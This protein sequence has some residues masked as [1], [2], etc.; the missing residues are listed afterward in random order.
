MKLF[1]LLFSIL[2]LNS[3]QAQSFENISVLDADSLIKANIENEDFV[4]MD[5]RTPSEYN[6]DHLENAYMRNFYDDD[7]QIQMDSLNKDFTY[8]IYCQSGNRSGQAF[9]IM[10]SLG[11]KTV[12]NMLGGISMWKNNNLPVT[13]E[14]PAAKNLYQVSSTNSIQQLNINLEGIDSTL[15]NTIEATLQSEDNV[16][17]TQLSN[18]QFQIE[19][20]EANLSNL[21]FCLNSSINANYNLSA[22]D[23]VKAQN[24]ALGLIDEPCP[25]DVLAADV[26]ESGNVS[27]AD[28]VEMANVLIGTRP[29]FSESPSLIFIIN[30]Q[31]QNCIDLSLN[32]LDQDGL[33]IQVIK[34]GD[35]TCAYE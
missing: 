2:F 7:F 25:N 18:F 19:S 24:I 23:I 5:V 3:I 20:D 32:D 12:Y 16:Q 31:K 6:R 15:L 28:L 1:P 11:F 29:T 27:G 4:I 30:E 35:L 26:N 8:L 34:K 13:T 21:K 22:S 9:T 10:Q 14:L 33:M 17:I